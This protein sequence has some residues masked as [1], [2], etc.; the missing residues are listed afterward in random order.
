[1]ISNTAPWITTVGASSI[2][3]EF[4]APVVLG[5][6]K[7]YR[8]SSLYKGKTLGNVQFPLVYGKTASSNKTSNFSDFSSFCV[9]GSLDLNMVSGKVVLCD[10]GL[11]GLD[12]MELEVKRAGGAGMIL[13][14]DPFLG[15]DLWTL[16]YFIPATCVD[17]K[18]GEAI[19]AY[20]NSTR[21]PTADIKADGLTV[22]GKAR[23]PVVA[24]FSSRGPNPMVPEI[25]KPDLIAPGVNILAA[26]MGR[27]VGPTGLQSDK[28]IIHY[29]I[30][31]GTSMSCPHVAGIAAL[32][33]AAHPEWTP[34]VIKSALMTSSV[35]FDNSKRVI[36]DS[37]TGLPANAFALGAGHVNPDAALDPGL[38]YDVGFDD[39][40]SFLCS[41][42]YNKTQIQILTGKKISC[43]KSSSQQPGDL[44]YPS[45][46]VVFK[47][48]DVVRV[49]RRTLTNVGGAP[50]VY[51]IAVESPP[52]VNI[53]VEPTTL[54][55]N[56]QN[57]KASFTVRFESNI[58]SDNTSSEL[59]N[60]GQI[61]W[62]CVKGGT[63][64]VRSPV[65]ITWE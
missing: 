26:W 16:T 10:I 58:A 9:A 37:G 23:A 60:F 45:F 1:L 21:N 19:K 3:R 2:D 14:N 54:V 39:Y 22:V 15:E 46:S 63:Q 42:N 44:N 25:L 11:A 30:E 24:A 56:E 41:L 29:N 59:Q 8:G 49:T 6:G 20:M 4:P 51:E 64:V 12:E 57:E 35:L 34:A 47:P 50:S 48:L 13:V 38:V 65:A 27:P 7:H 55:F 32:L 18:S 33:R 31:S 28:R 17:S 5:N 36:H 53:T 43:N 61:W 52:S 40:V 62:K